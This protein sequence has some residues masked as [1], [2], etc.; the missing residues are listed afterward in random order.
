MGD[1]QSLW[2]FSQRQRV[3]IRIL[4]PGHSRTAWSQPNAVIVLTQAVVAHELD[5]GLGQLLNRFSNIGH[6]PTEHRVVDPWL[7]LYLLN[8]QL[9]LANLEYKGKRVISHELQSESILIKLSRSF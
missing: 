8:A 7:A 3:L 9:K 5:A 6:R 2:I 1:G 4:K